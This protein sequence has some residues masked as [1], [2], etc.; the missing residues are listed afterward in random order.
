MWPRSTRLVF[1]LPAPETSPSLRGALEVFLMIAGTVWTSLVLTF[2][3]ALQ[4]DV[5]DKG[6]TPEYT[7][8]MP[9]LNG[10]GVT[11]LADL[12]GRPVLVEFWG[13]Q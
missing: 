8:R 2:G 3:T 5:V 4:A 12:A 10:Q 1:R 9:M 11:C 13:T 7:F 6:D